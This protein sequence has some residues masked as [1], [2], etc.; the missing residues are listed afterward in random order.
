[1]PVQFAARI[2]MGAVTER[3][4]GRRAAQLLLL[5]AVAGIVGAAIGTPAG[6]KERARMAAALGWDPPAALI[7]DAFAI[8]TPL[9]I[10]IAIW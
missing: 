4:S 7:E 2:V 6:Q 1:V 9:L 5:G 3:R 10:V 8:V